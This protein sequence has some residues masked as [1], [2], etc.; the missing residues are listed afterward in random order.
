MQT[1]VPCI[2]ITESDS[3]LN[4]QNADHLHEYSHADSLY[5]HANYEQVNGQWVP[6]AYDKMQLEF[7]ML[8]PWVRTTLKVF[9]Y[10]SFC[11]V[12]FVT[13]NGLGYLP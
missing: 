10:L 11:H 3:V 13:L 5:V 1:L 7:V 6:Y 2:C 9:E 4:H 12:G 8:D